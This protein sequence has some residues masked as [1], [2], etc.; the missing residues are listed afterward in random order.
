MALNYNLGEGGENKKWTQG[1]QKPVTPRKAD[2]KFMEKGVP[3]R[4]FDLL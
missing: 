1:V 4:V 2:R 3:I